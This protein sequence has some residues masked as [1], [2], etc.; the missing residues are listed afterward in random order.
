MN[1]PQA[2]E[3]EVGMMRA[4][5]GKD[6]RSDSEDALADLSDPD[7]HVDKLSYVVSAVSHKLLPDGSAILVANAETANTEAPSLPSIWHT[8]PILH[9][10][11]LP[12]L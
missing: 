11:N 1:T 3:R 9:E 6:Y 5:F 4:V 7:N 8:A 10:R 2:R 12:C